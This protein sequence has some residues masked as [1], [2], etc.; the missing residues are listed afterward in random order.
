[1]TTSNIQTAVEDSLI[2]SIRQILNHLGMIDVE[3]ILANQGG[4]EPTTTYGAIN[5]IDKV[6]VG[7]VQET[8]GSPIGQES[9]NYYTN[10]YT[11]SVQ[12]SFI[13]A[14]SGDVMA[15]F[16]DSVFSSRRC[17]E[18][19]QMHKLGALSQ[20]GSRRIPQLRETT[21]VSAYNIDLNLSFAV[22]SH[23]TIDWIEFFTFGDNYGFNPTPTP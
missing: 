22:Q 15:E 1:M 7:R 16:E 10:Y 23:E 12:I 11:L 8:V 13:G 14:D 21:W 18:F 2:A 6:R 19:L 17:I 3:V 20:S 5:I 4:L 9:E